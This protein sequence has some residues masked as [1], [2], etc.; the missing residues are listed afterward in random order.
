M[1]SVYRVIAGLAIVSAMTTGCDEFDAD[2]EALLNVDGSITE[3]DDAGR[4]ADA[5]ADA[6]ADA[7]DTGSSETTPDSA[8][9]PEIELSDTCPNVGDLPL[10]G[11]S[12][13]SSLIDV[14]TLTSAA[15]ASGACDISEGVLYGSDAF[16]KVNAMAGDRWHF[17]LNSEPTADMALFV[18][19][20]CDRRSC[21]SAADEC[22]VGE[23]EHF[24]FIAESDGQYVVGIEGIDPV[25]SNH[26]LLLA[27]HPTCG[28]G[29]EDHGEGCDDNNTSSGDGCDSWCRTELMEAIADEVE[30]NDDSYGANVLLAVNPGDSRTLKGQIGGC[31]ADFFKLSVTTDS[32]A[33]FVM[34]SGNPNCA[35]PSLKLELWNA[36]ADT[37]R[38]AGLRQ[39]AVV[40]ESGACP[41]FYVS[42]LPAGD[43]FLRVSS[44]ETD[45][46]PYELQVDTL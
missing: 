35:S 37:I 22:G 14:S 10:F 25:T 3:S 28:D 30:P 9:L 12:N 43:Y 15:R 33:S 45:E 4:L 42:E 41:A 39:S 24:T 21:L 8:P 46:V 19:S 17:H 6:D 29:V 7:P 13:R 26:V 27:I 38:T 16:F 44:D 20:T 18:S 5:D 32:Y 40:S 36:D 23:A 2:M 1:R 34:N 11:G 31:R